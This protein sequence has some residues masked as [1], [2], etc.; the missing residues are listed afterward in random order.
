MLKEVLSQIKDSDY[1]SKSKI[2]MNLN[3]SV[4][5]IEDAFSQLIRMGY[6]RVNNIDNCNS[7]CSGCFLGN[8]C[9]SKFLTKSIIITDK[10]KQLLEK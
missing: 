3:K 8:S 6:I 7:N 5:L 2:A 1:I 9:T 10:G 4:D